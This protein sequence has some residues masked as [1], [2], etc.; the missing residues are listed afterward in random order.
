MKAS[1]QV[2]TSKGWGSTFRFHESSKQN[3]KKINPKLCKQ[4]VAGEGQRDASHRGKI[5]A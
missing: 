3:R 1:G 5:A 2:N 4:M